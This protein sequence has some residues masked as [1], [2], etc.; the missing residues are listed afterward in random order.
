MAVYFL[1]S[2]Q[3]PRFDPNPFFHFVSGKAD[4]TFEG[5]CI[6][7]S[8]CRIGP[9]WPRDHLN[10]T[11][12]CLIPLMLEHEFMVYSGIDLFIDARQS[13]IFAMEIV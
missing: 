3:G 4:G 9:W 12:E 10:N 5:R 2:R 8:L 13:I 1:P 11:F 6:V 7:G